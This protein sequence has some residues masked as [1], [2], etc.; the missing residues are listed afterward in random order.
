M[1]HVEADRSVAL[2]YYSGVLR[3][4]WWVVLLCAV[5]GG[6]VAASYLWVVP[7]RATST[8][9][10]SL[11][12]I[13]SDPFD[14]TRS[15]SN[16]IDMDSEAEIAA[17]SVVAD[18][19]A[20]SRGGDLGAEAIRDAVDVTG[21]GT[22]SILRVAASGD[23][24][25]QSEEVADMVA[26][27][28]LGYRSDQAQ[29]RIDR[30]LDG[31]RTRLEGLRDDLATA[32][33][34]VAAAT[35]AED[36]DAL[37]QAETRRSLV[38]LEINS[39]LEQVST[40]QAIDT[41][42]GSILT[43]ASRDAV[44]FSPSRNIVL[45]TGLLVGLV[46]GLL[47]AF[48]SDALGRRVR[49]EGDVTHNGGRSLLGR[50]DEH[51]TTVPARTRELDELRAIRERMLADPHLSTQSGV[52]GIL[53]EDAH[54][55]ASAVGLNLALVLAEA[56]IR[57]EY[58]GVELRQ[59]VFDHLSATHRLQ[60]QPEHPDV[61][62]SGSTPNLSVFR[63]SA[64][65]FAR[66]GLSGAVRRHLRD[67]RADVLVVVDVPAGVSEATRLATC[68]LSDTVVLVLGHGRTRMKQLRHDV[69]GVRQ[70][71]SYVLGTILVG[72]HRSLILSTEE[73]GAGPA[74]DGAT[75]RHSAMKS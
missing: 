57:V 39:L 46:L 52:L 49:S 21:V 42:A 55:T 72:R 45:A 34:Q 37:T 74:E 22:S 33:E 43:P 27:E 62:V 12:I 38:T 69:A 18:R 61:Y 70:M 1:Q 63:E 71:G 54:G 28:Y 66:E 7:Q 75:P 24:R 17:S 9:S 16:L 35:E 41:T 8:T 26:T 60:V 50:L 58:I 13:T 6:L 36:A 53:N 2:S 19:V 73:E 48:L 64:P 30:T 10:V 59:D 25:A 15:A 14:T 40:T 47:F 11:N 68:R 23:S 56:G 29:A 20:E 5:L 31:A 67:G 44:S 32:N 51:E 4:R 3:R 65:E